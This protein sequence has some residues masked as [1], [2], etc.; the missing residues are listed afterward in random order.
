[1]SAG[2]VLRGEAPAK[3]N[4]ELRVGPRRADGFHE[5]RSR[6]VTIDL[7]DEIEVQS[8]ARLDLTCDLPG[9]SVGP[10]NLVAR[11]A[12]ALAERLGL[13]PLVRLR[14][15]KRIPVGAGLGGGSSDAAVTLRLLSRLWG[16]T[17]PDADLASIA[18]ELGSDVAFFL[19][20]GE[21]DV[22][23]RGES[24]SLREDG[25][26]E[27]LILI[28]PPFSISTAAVY[29]AFDRTGG[30][31][32]PP[33]LL[34]IEESGRFFGPNDLEGAVLAV[35]PEMANYL[36]DGR[37][38]A[39]ECAVTGSG[40]TLVLVGASPE[41]VAALLRNHPGARAIPTRTMGRREY[42]NRIGADRAAPPA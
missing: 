33:A 2:R 40:S 17:V 4:R 36:A 12:M 23:G 9:L 6:L 34:E 16:R 30:A 18:A 24:V 10:S 22:G 32:S 28:V 39:R 19:F 42:L 20:G 11:A 3:I 27:S 38:V 31:S 25:P 15:S 7:S 5:I 41:A 14:L 21:A 8:A 1:M 13:E 37:R 35:A 26:R 29:E